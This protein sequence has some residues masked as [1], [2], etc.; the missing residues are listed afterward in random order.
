MKKFLMALAVTTMA[1]S[2]VITAQAQ[3][4]P[5]QTSKKVTQKTVKKTTSN[6]QGKRVVTKTVTRQK[7]APARYN[8]TSV[9]V[10]QNHRNWSKGQKF[11]RRYATNYRVIDNPRAYRLS[12]AP[13]GYQWV[14][15]GNDAVL[16][17]VTSGI[18]GAVIGN[19]IAR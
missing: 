4:A 17:A 7:A 18:I 14:R 12:N 11:D 19:A 15:S 2:P 10:K 1:V 5:H 9:A 8:R 3:A 6:K 16:I 13:R